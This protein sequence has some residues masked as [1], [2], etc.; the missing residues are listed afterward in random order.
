MVADVQQRVRELELQL[1]RCDSLEARVQLLLGLNDG[2]IVDA[3]LALK[4]IFEQELRRVQQHG[5]RLFELRLA[6]RLSDI[7]RHCGANEEAELH[8][9]RVC[10]IGEELGEPRFI[11]SGWYLIGQVEQARCNYEAAVECYQQALAQWRK[12]GV[13]RGVY[14]ALNGLGNVAGLL[15][16]FTE[17]RGY[18]QQCRQLLEDPEFDDLVRATNFC[19]L[20]WVYLQLG[21]WDDAEE[22]LYR[23]VALAEQQGYDFIRYSALNLLGEQFLKRDRLERAVEVFRTVVEAGRKGLTAAELLR[24]SLTNLGEAEFRRHSYAAASQAFAEAIELCKANHDRL[25]MSMLLW[26]LA[27][28]ELAQGNLDRCAGLCQQ[29]QQLAE[30]L[31]ARNV[32]AEV[33][34]VRALL[35][36]ERGMT[37]AARF[38]F[39]QARQLLGEE[40]E[41][42]ES[43]RVRLQYGHF[44]LRHSERERAAE[45]L[46]FASRVF[47]KLGVVAE[48]DAVNRLLFELEL[49]ADREIALVA[50]IAGLSLTGLEPVKFLEGSLKMI[51]EALG[52]DGAALVVNR[53]LRVCH[54]E[55]NLEPIEPK[56]SAPVIEEHQVVVPVSFSREAFG[57]LYLERKAPGVPLI[58]PSVLTTVASLLVP[59][60][61]KVVSFSEELPVPA[62]EIP[63]LRFDGVIGRSAEMRKNL[64]VIVRCADSTLPVLI[65][66]ESG[67]GKELVARAIHFTSSRCN[68]PF[69]PINCVAIPESLLEAE[70]FGVEKGAATGVS[71]RK[72]KFEL[73]DGG[74]VFLDEIGDMSPGL[75]AKLLRVLQDK[76]FERVGGT[77]P[78]RVD[79]RVVAATNQDLQQLIKA[80]RFREDLYYRLNGIEICLPPLRERREDIPELVRFFVARANQE[81]QRQVRGVSSDVMRLFMTYDWPGNVRQLRNVIAR[82][83]VLARGDEIQVDDLP[84]ELR[85]LDMA[86]PDNSRTSLKS[87]KKL[88]REKAGAEM[89]KAMLLECIEKAHGNIKK[90]AEFSGYSRA[91]FYR[92]LKKHDIKFR[93]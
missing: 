32:L 86:T 35:E 38:F 80:G 87:V 52:F 4:P 82:A 66:G 83:V 15:G 27:E 16:R 28:L 3:A 18:Y 59:A 46:K 79:V 50:G 76:T 91:Q 69:V 25:N 26:R 78:V 14:A 9:R 49:D 8:A 77:R 24:D 39:E 10:K 75:Q 11:A 17:A 33:Y 60:V 44:L 36:S 63:G 90:A 57:N 30:E 74:T 2:F 20:G 41:S 81:T 34:R 56:G 55:I 1:E 61:E 29:A 31:D 71:A 58:R 67:T 19:N 21:E 53:K 43:A 64:E 5:R 23:A 47:R 54:G 37:A 70:F 40:P 62:L 12:A 51:C 73:A 72:G 93:K 48:T 42:Y 88:V 22:N 84:A 92:L 85:Q 89:E 7:C 6:R 45:E 65:R 13:R 68:R